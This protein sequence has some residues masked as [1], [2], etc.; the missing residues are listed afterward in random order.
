MTERVY[1]PHL[2]EMDD[3]SLFHLEDLGIINSVFPK[4]KYVKHHQWMILTPEFVLFLKTN[5]MALN[6]LAFM[7]HSYIPD[8]MY[9]GTGKVSIYNSSFNQFS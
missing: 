8:E 3:S 7:E 6:F 4:W 5:I 1:R 2:K 9:F